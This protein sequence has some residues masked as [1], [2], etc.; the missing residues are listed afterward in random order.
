[1]R[2]IVHRSIFFVLGGLLMATTSD[3]ALKAGDPAP[4]VSAPL[5]DG[6]TFHLKEWLNRAPL[7]RYFDRKD[8]TPGCT[9]EACGLRDDF[10]AFRNLKATVIGVS[11]DS[12]E[13]HQKFIEKYHLPF[14]L[15]ADTDKSIAKAFGVAGMFYAT[16][17]TFII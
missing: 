8:D 6:T 13:S 7:V 12:V 15:A 2:S 14:P 16:R 9:K 5:S 10:S 3:A 11:Y 4:E 1:M 17:A